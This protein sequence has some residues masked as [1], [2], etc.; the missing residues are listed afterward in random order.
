MTKK[1]LNFVTGMWTID[2]G[3]TAATSSDPKNGAQS[4][5]LQGNIS[6]Q[7]RQGIISMEFDLVGVKSISISYGIYP[8]NAEVN[9]IN[10]TIFDIEVSFDNGETYTPV[11]T[12]E[13][14]TSSR[15]LS[16]SSFSIDAGFSKKVRFRIVNSSIPFTNGNKPRINI[17][18]FVFNF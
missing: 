7:T 15:D 9:N 2:G 17:D 13:V 18:D 1:T 12:V 3:I 11:G 8:A 4:I 16:T 14:D 5:R 10:P 6:N